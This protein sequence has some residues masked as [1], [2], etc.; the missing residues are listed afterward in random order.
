MGER[1]LMRATA[2]ANVPREYQSLADL[3]RRERHRHQQMP[4][5]QQECEVRRQA[6]RAADAV[7]SSP[8]TARRLGISPRTLRHWRRQDRLGTQ[9][10]CV[11]G[12][13][14]R[15]SSRCEKMEALDFMHRTGPHVGLPTLRAALP[16]LPRCQLLDLQR[17]YR[18]WFRKHH[19]QG[20]QRLRWH[21]PGTVWAV[22]HS[23]APVLIDGVFKTIFAVRDLASGMQ[24]AWLP[25]P[26][27][28]A[29]HAIPIVE[30][31]M[32]AH[33]APLVLKSD[34][35]SAFISDDW[36]RLL[37]HWHV[38]ALYSPARHPQFNGSIESGIGAMKVRTEMLS[39]THGRGGSWTEQV[40][41]AA[42]Y[43]A[44]H[45]HRSE[46]D[47]HRSAFQRWHN[48]QSITDKERA[49]FRLVLDAN[50]EKVQNQVEQA[51]PSSCISPKQAKRI[52]RKAITQTLVELDLLSVTWRSIPLPFNAPKTARLS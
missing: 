19:R 14:C 9:Q 3:S 7:R 47:P 50:T 8:H 49:E 39:I 26:S 35:G 52:T 48:R 2:T 5:R 18:R 46:R 34:N 45:L 10:P 37:R 33:G 28:A 13:P 16:H 4:R 31:L 29:E 24:L 12:R 43:Q 21:R 27:T 30:S 40:M 44:N 15:E 51:D 20:Q 17:D 25:V 23:E 1:H 38:T 11:T 6:A 32:Q 22:D 36:S 42:R 41:Q